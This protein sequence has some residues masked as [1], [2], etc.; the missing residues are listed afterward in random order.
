MTVSGEFRVAETETN[1]Q[2]LCLVKERLCNG[3]WHFSLIPVISLSD[4]V[5][6]PAW[7]ESSESQFG[8]DHEITA[9]LMPLAQECDESL[10]NFFTCVILL[11]GTH[12]RSADSN[13]ATHEKSS[14]LAS[15][16]MV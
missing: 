7:E 10:N 5:D 8:K 11:D 14:V 6:E 3:R 2:F 12:L 15:E 1:L 13:N 16:I 4:V 9:C